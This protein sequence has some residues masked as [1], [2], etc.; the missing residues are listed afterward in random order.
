MLFNFFPGTLCFLTPAVNIF[1]ENI[2]AKGEIAISPFATMFS[3]LFYNYILTSRDFQ[4]FCLEV[5]KVDYCRFVVCR[6]G[7]TETY[8]NGSRRF[9]E[10]IQ[11]Q[12]ANLYE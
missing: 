8:N 4:Y 9:G 3:T 10:Y 12:M 2:M 6:Q 1:F 7:L 5:F 11:G